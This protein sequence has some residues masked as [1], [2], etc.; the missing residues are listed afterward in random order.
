MNNSDPGQIPY[1][2]ESQKI[3]DA[4][5]KSDEA[6]ALVVVERM[7][8]HPT[9]KMQ[10]TAKNQVTVKDSPAKIM[11]QEFGG[12]IKRTMTFSDA[13]ELE[14][15]GKM[16]T[17]PEIEE[18]VP[19]SKSSN[20]DE[21]FKADISKIIGN[22]QSCFQEENFE[23][24]T[25]RQDGNSNFRKLSNETES[26]VV[27]NETDFLLAPKGTQ[28][29]VSVRR[30]S[31]G[32]KHN[33]RSTIETDLLDGE[34]DFNTG[35]VVSEDTSMF[36]GQV[37]Q[38]TMPNS[39]LPKKTI[40]KI[41]P[42]S[43][44]VENWTSLDN[45]LLQIKDLETKRSEINDLKSALNNHVKIKTETATDDDDTSILCT[46][47]QLNGQIEKINSKINTLSKNHENEMQSPLGGKNFGVQKIDAGSG[48]SC[49]SFL[50]GSFKT[51]T[52]NI[53]LNTNFNSNFVVAPTVR[54]LPES[55]DQSPV[56]IK[57]FRSSV[58]GGGILQN[59]EDFHKKVAGRCQTSEVKI[60][61]TS[62]NNFENV[63]SKFDADSLK[64]GV[65]KRIPSVQCSPPKPRDRSMNE[66]MSDVQSDLRQKIEKLDTQIKAINES[67][68][69]E[70]TG[71][72]QAFT[73]L[74]G[75]Q[76]STKRNSSVKDRR[77]TSGAPIP[78]PFQQ[79]GIQKFP[80]RASSKAIAK[81]LINYLDGGTEFLDRGQINSTPLNPPNQTLQIP[82]QEC[83]N[84][85]N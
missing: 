26:I 38:K 73:S 23:L 33:I 11:S 34:F 53:N 67:Y 19:C 43:S 14:Y 25:K 49:R 77:P 83:N 3:F 61:K 56:S 16:A 59:F 81:P 78:S 28:V 1:L 10:S 46:I 42:M 66:K 35:P 72:S 30:S 63:V 79:I 36:E 71:F 65:V 60:I 70:P 2:T 39:N 51:E 17:H 7:K 22:N 44:R 54:I 13:P 76:E 20:S 37:E 12:M 27:L 8:N 45:T 74:A 68:H 32:R 18:E 82:T 29:E 84:D 52:L 57:P 5:E 62:V 9:M 47:N 4:E 48:K 40:P 55:G 50:D 41:I 69:I 85:A 31:T 64:Q 58:V 21:K 6:Q 80:A 24:F 75:T 15:E